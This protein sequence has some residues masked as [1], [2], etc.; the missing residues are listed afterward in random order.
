MAFFGLACPLCVVL[1]LLFFANFV[2]NN[3]VF[4]E[5]SNQHHMREHFGSTA[6]P[7]YEHFGS[8]ADCGGI[9]GDV[10]MCTPPGQLTSEVPLSKRC[11][12]SNYVNQCKHAKKVPV[13]RDTEG[14]VYNFAPYNRIESL[15][16]TVPGYYPQRESRCDNLAVRECLA[17]PRCGWLTNRGGL[18]GRCVRGTP[19]GPANPRHIPDPED[20]IRGNITLDNWKY[21]HPNPF[22]KQFF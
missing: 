2:Y 4:K 10:N 16:L 21:A 1:L 3:A 14:S 11:L 19:I 7:T 9:P 18:Y 15:N 5:I 17:E 8:A 12:L 20:A 6:R 22:I 13:P